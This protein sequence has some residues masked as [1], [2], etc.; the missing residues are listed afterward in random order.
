MG[1]GFVLGFT[2][3]TFAEFFDTELQLDIDH[4]KYKAEG[5]SKA[6][7]LRY[8]LKTCDP[9]LRTRTLLSLW[10]YR[11]DERRRERI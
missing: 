4:P 6:K 10:E 2:D 5:T 3:R 7:R 11:E 1:A 9:Q 8:F